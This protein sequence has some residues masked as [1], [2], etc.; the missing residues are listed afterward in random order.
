MS[1]KFLEAQGRSDYQSFEVPKR[2][3]TV[4]RQEGQVVRDPQTNTLEDL[5]ELA[6]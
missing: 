3:G 4:H 1:F 6:K 5:G 2:L